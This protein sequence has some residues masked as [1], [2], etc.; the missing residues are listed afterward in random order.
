M[1]TLSLSLRNLL[2]NRRRS[3]ATLL[4]IA[5]G[6]MSILLFGGFSANIQYTMETTHIRMGGHLQIQHSDFQ[7]FG[8]GNPIA[9]GIGGADIIIKAIL[10][11]EI[12]S[13][14]T[15]VVTP[16]LQFGGIAG[17]Y[18][19]GVSQ[20]ILGTGLVAQDQSRMR[21]WNDYDIPILA[22]PLKLSGTPPDSA[23]IGTGLARLL[24]LCEVM[25]IADCPKEV[26]ASQQARG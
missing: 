24:Q 8:T 11:D 18:S 26:P 1:E 21:E 3:L 20:T 4:A 12:L 17:N 23:V 19:V 5:I 10:G 13:K 7:T 14:M 16:L 2:R 9:Y 25:Q 15:L 6:S 22:T